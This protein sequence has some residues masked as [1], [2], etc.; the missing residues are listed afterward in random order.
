[1]P[2]GGG[3]TLLEDSVSEGCEAESSPAPREAGAL[4][5]L[6]S[7]GERLRA[8]GGMRF[9]EVG[10]EVLVRAEVRLQ[11]PAEVLFGGA[12]EGLVGAEVLFE[13]PAGVLFGGAAEVL[14]KADVCFSRPC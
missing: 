7:S 14:V 6:P 2:G 10:A 9:T 1:M 4:L 8:A 11:G 13:G 12:V 5:A 3:E